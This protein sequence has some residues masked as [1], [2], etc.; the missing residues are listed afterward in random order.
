MCFN[1]EIAPTLAQGRPK[2][3]REVREM[4]FV[5]ILLRNFGLQNCTATTESFPGKMP[6]KWGNIHRWRNN[7][8]QLAKAAYIT[9]RKLGRACQHL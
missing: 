1:Q 3:T 7:Q 8:Q 4:M 9:L 2:F 5:K 6:P